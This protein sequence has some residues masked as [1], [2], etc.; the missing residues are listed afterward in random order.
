MTPQ[1]HHCGTTGTLLSF[2][3]RRG[4][5]ISPRMPGCPRKGRG[6]MGVE[7]LVGAGKVGL[8]SWLDKEVGNGAWGL[9]VY[10]DL[11]P[12]KVNSGT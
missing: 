1:P 11:I 9:C 6:L 2:Q 4:H 7:G 10:K 3:L 12:V 5:K 8:Y